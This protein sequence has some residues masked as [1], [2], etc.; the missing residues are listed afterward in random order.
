V[1]AAIC[2][3]KLCRA[4]GSRTGALQTDGSVAAGAPEV[5]GKLIDLGDVSAGTSGTF[6][7]TYGYQGTA[8]AGALAAFALTGCSGGTGAATPASPAGRHTGPNPSVS[9]PPSFAGVQH[10]LPSDAALAN[11]PDLY[12]D[13]TLTACSATAKGWQG[14]GTLKNTADHAITA[15]VVVLFTDAQARD[16]DSATTK[17]EVAPGATARWTAARAFDAPKGTRCVLRAV[18]PA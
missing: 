1:L 17:V 15:T 4:R 12:K 7:V 10:A 9:P 11:D 5:T 2:T 14:V 13:A 3:A 6:S 16:V 8:L 18:R